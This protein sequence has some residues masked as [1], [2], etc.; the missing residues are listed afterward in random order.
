MDI[1]NNPFQEFD[2][3]ITTGDK[4]P[5]KSVSSYINPFQEFGGKSVAVNTPVVAPDPFQEFDGQNITT[6]KDATNVVAPQIKP[7]LINYPGSPIQKRDDFDSNWLGDLLV[8]EHANYKGH[9]KLT[10]LYR[11]LAGQPLQNNI[12]SISNVKPTNSK[13]Q[14]AK[15]I[16]I[17]DPDF[18][19]QVVDNYKRVTTGGLNKLG[20][21][22]L[23][24]D[25]TQEQQTGP[26][27]YNI[28]AYHQKGGSALGHYTVSKG[29][30]EKGDYVSYYDKFNTSYGSGGLGILKPFEVYGRVYF[31]PNTNQIIP[32]GELK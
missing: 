19:Q 14:N 5:A 18:K 15:Y 28:S 13:D 16:S 1:N 21:E 26:N 24:D 8:K 17:N 32:D 6:K 10:D 25:Y 3:N 22:G 9:G 31:D 30:D 4:A 20:K 7:S 12:L 29:N 27:T 11:Y 2:G 23:S